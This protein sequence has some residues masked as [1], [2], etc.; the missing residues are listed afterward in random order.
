MTTRSRPRVQAPDIRLHPALDPRLRDVFIR[1]RAIVLAAQE[2]A[3]QAVDRANKIKEALR[4]DREGLQPGQ[5]EA[6]R[7]V[8]LLHLAVEEN[9][10][11]ARNKDQF[12][13]TVSHEL[14]QPLNAALAAMRLIEV[15]GD[16]ASK[17]RDILRRQLLQ[18]A[19]LIDDLLDT[20]RMSLD[21]LDLRLGHVDV[22]R[23]LAEAVA[24][25]EP[26]L[27]PRQLTLVQQ[28][29]AG[30][31]C[32]W[33]DESRLRQ[34]FSNLLANAVRNSPS[35]GRITL[36][37]RSDRATVVVSVS[38]TGRGINAAD[39]PHTFDPFTRR[40]EEREGFGIGLSIVRGI[41]ELHRGSVRADSPGPG[42]GSTFSVILPLCACTGLPDEPGS[43]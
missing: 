29:L 14:R 18:M 32:V 13:A 19:R 41:V 7:R 42:Q 17:A 31:A 33:G 16:S 22:P 1:S 4:A 38:D 12:L 10:R 35:G 37:R 3:Q 30:N 15:G 21:I 26:A 24:T 23:V 28:Q 36:S 25:I 34:V 6:R 40:T 43:L 20:S 5:R 8:R 27:A 39:L 9:A 11:S 2:R